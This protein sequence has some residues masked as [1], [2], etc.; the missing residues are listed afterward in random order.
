MPRPSADCGRLS[1][2]QLKDDIY[3]I[4]DE[5]FWSEPVEARLRQMDAISVYTMYGPERY[6][7]YA[8]ESGFLKDIDEVFSKY[9]RLAREL[10]IGFVP[11][12]TPGFNDRGVPQDKRM[13]FQA[14]HYII[15]RAFAIDNKDEGSFYRLYFQMARRHLDPQLNLVL[16]NSWNGWRDDTQIEPVKVS[17]K[18]STQP[19]D[20]TSGYEYQPYGE[21]Y[22]TI[23]KESGK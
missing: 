14:Q 6:S 18:P 19:H 21:L 10:K 3:L 17:G 23:T 16:I 4:G 9:R 22:L 1:G 5:I 11:N 7:G 12:V 13:L 20:L 15:P 8:S 2:R